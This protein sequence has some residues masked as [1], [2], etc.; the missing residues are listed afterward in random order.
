MPVFDSAVCLLCSTPWWKS[1]W[2]FQTPQMLWGKIFQYGWYLGC[3]LTG[4]SYF[5]FLGSMHA[6]SLSKCF[7]LAGLDD[8]NGLTSSISTFRNASHA[9]A[10]FYSSSLLETG[11]SKCQDL[12]YLLFPW[13]YRAE[14]AWVGWVYLCWCSSI[15]IW[16]KTTR[17]LWKPLKCLICLWIQWALGRE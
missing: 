17:N 13:L 4:S 12:P 16:A 3:S 6:H 1:R 15:T 8:T 11:E 5:F 10:N 9:L 7:L 14:W 2:V